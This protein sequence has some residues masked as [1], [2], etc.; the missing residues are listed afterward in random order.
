MSTA[1]PGDHGGTAGSWL[2]RLGAAVRQRPW[3]FPVFALLLV[4]G[5]LA[6]IA[7][8]V[9]LT[10]FLITVLWAWVVPDL[11]PGAVAQGLIAPTV[12]WLA[13]LKILIAS[14]FFGALIGA[15]ASRRRQS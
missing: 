3:L 7:A 1:L 9:V 4:P 10:L 5:L 11:F 13:A 15:S 6:L 8:V 12:S 2:R 14:L